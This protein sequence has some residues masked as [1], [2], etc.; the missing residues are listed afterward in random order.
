MT[1]Q[2]L[3]EPEIE[4][5]LAKLDRYVDPMFSRAAA[6]IRQL[7]EERRSTMTTGDLSG[8]SLTWKQRYEKAAA[9]LAEAEGKIAQLKQALEDVA[10]V[11]GEKAAAH[12]RAFVAATAPQEPTP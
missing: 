5:L 1:D 6:A 3:R 7:R 2:R 12:I 8:Q 4:A 11:C 10:L 9:Q